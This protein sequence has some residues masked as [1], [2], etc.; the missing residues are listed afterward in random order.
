LAPSDYPINISDLLAMGAQRSMESEE[1][2]ITE[3]EERRGSIPTLSTSRRGSR[4]QDILR[5]NQVPN[6]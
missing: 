6:F 2:D 5:F 1:G 4:L 3:G